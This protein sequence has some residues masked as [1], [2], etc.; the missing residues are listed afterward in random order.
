MHQL[1]KASFI[2]CFCF[3]RQNLNIYST[4]KWEKLNKQTLKT[5][6]IISMMT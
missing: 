5:E 2:H 3:I 4:Y 1:H 6:L